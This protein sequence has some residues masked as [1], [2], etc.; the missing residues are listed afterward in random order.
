MKLN[1]VTETGT[2]N[3]KVVNTATVQTGPAVLVMASQPG[4]EHVYATELLFL[5]DDP[6]F[7]LIHSWTH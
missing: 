7:S 4:Y 3:I 6:P 1:D 2:E 5:V